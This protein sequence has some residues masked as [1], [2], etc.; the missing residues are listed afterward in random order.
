MEFVSIFKLIINTHGGGSQMFSRMD[1][2][3]EKASILGYKGAA[4]SV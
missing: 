2:S 4:H 1:G 3:F